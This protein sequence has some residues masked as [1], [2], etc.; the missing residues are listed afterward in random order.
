M[1]SPR[2]KLIDEVRI[3]LGGGVVRVEL[4]PE[5][6]DLALDMALDRYR[7]RSANSVEERFAPLELQAGQHTYILPDEVT[8]VRQI[9]RRSATGTGATGVQFDPFST[10]F[11]NSMILNGTLGNGGAGDLVTYELSVQ[12]QELIGKMFGLYMT[13]QFENVSKKLS[14]DRNIIT[15]ETV[16]LWIYCHRPEGVLLGDTYAR[17]WLRD[18]TLA[19]CKVMLGEIRGKFASF[20]GPQGGTSLNGDALKNEGLA[21]MERLENEVKTQVDQ[22]MGYGFI[23]G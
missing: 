5:A 15:N 1:K 2:Q 11:T 13:Y 17:S 9:Y 7:Q 20:A 14:V 22:S 21:E 18:W 4:K 10:A 23:I 6:F 19:R 16:L 12:Y 3:L 8:E